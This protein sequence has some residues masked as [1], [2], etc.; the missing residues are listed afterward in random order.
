MSATIRLLER[1][2][3]A[4]RITS[5]NAAALELGIGRAAISRWRS[6]DTNAE[7]ALIA[8]MAN[9][10]KA[11]PAPWILAA[12]AEKQKPESRKVLMDMVEPRRMYETRD[13]EIPP[14]RPILVPRREKRV[15]GE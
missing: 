12:E 10:L 7:P 11:D 13:I 6:D 9:D 5:D 2:K 14:S 1:W 3:T 15:S 8:R 4:L